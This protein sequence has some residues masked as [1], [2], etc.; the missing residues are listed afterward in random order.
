M[1]PP[2]A[3]VE[4]VTVT[5]GRLVA[6]NAVSCTFAVGVTGV[7][8]P[9]GAG[10]STLFRVLVGLQRFRV[11]RVRTRGTVGYL[12]QDMRLY[13]GF[14]A[15]EILRY[16]GWVK[17]LPASRA[18]A[19]AVRCL[20]LMGMSASSHSQV[21]ALSGGMQQRLVIASAF[22]GDPDLLVLDEPTVGLDMEQ[23]VFFRDLIRAEGAHRAVVISSHIAMDIVRTCSRVVV[24]DR[25]R[26]VHT[27]PVGSFGA[28]DTSTRGQR[29]GSQNG[30]RSSDDVG[31]FE[32]A[33]LRLLGHD[34]R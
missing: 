1:V 29:S 11:G 19:E 3:V 17:G 5:H 25:G 10:K 21:R 4:D 24:L 15:A 34:S 20:A 27:G 9:N 8:G 16:V 33:Y 23:Q 6:L 2:V 18:R 28:D 12:P 22:V 30:G 14:T 26:L 31:R 32:D 13:K 7:L